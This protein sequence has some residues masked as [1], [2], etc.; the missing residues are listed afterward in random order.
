[1]THRLY[2]ITHHSDGCEKTFEGHY[3]NQKEKSME[4]LRLKEG[5]HSGLKERKMSRMFLKRC[6]EELLM[7][8]NLKNKTHASV[9][10]N[11]GLLG[12]I[13]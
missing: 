7:Y 9:V 13:D 12:R 11:N 3:K 1:M 2:Y 4:S 10:S 5:S 8:G 6:F